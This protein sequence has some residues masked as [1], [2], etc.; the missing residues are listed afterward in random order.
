MRRL[1]A[2]LRN[3]LAI[4][5]FAAIYV[6]VLLALL[7]TLLL[8]DETT[9]GDN[10]TTVIER[11]VDYSPWMLLIA[12]VFVPVAAGLAWIWS[13]RAIRPIERAIAIQN[14]LIEETSH[15]LRTPLTILTT[16]ADVIRTHP[17]PTDDL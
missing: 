12:A 16:N 1:L 17:E 5:A 15:E 14:H 3:R 10:G 6:P 13:G 7:S 11:G 8:S 4:G 2:P 9:T